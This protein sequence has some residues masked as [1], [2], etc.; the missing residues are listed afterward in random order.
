MAT[1]QSEMTF[2]NSRDAILDKLN[3]KTLTVIQVFLTIKRHNTH[4]YSQLVTSIKQASKKKLYW[5]NTQYHQGSIYCS[6]YYYNTHSKRCSLFNIELQQYIKKQTIWLKL[7]N[8]KF[9]SDCSI[10]TQQGHGLKRIQGHKTKKWE[11][12]AEGRIHKILLSHKLRLSQ[13]ND[14]LQDKDWKYESLPNNLL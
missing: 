5:I 10:G 6:Y 12:T 9:H 13:S 8:T 3:Y 11:M 4:K 14:M 2:C 7:P 1:H